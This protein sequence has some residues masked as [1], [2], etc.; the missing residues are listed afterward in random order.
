[1]SRKADRDYRTAAQ[2]L[3]R[4]SHR[5]KRRG[6]HKPRSV[7]DS[8]SGPEELSGFDAFGT[9]SQSPQGGTPRIP[10]PLGSSSSPPDATALGQP[11]HE[12]WE[13]EDESRSPLEN[14]LYGALS[15]PGGGELS[16]LIE[17]LRVV[18]DRLESLLPARPN[19]RS[20]IRS[21]RRG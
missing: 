4:A 10:V 17:L 8:S 3:D 14:V 19:K 21:P 20:K 15:E 6:R 12:T 5:V 1:M 11:A 9:S 13:D 18:A 16:Q 7:V 2:F